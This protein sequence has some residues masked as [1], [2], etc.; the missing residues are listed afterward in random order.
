MLVELA[1]IL[2]IGLVFSSNEAMCWTAR[3]NPAILLVVFGT[4][5]QEAQA[6]YEYIKKIYQK[7]FPS[8]KVKI[9]FTSASIRRTIMKRSNTSIDNPLTGLAHLNDEGYVNVVV[10]SLHMI[11][12][13]EFHDLA[14]VVDSIKGIR[15][16]FEFK[17]LVLGAPLL[18]TMEDYRD[19]SRILSKQFDENKTGAER[20]PHPSPKNFGKMAI[21]LMGHGTKHSLTR[22]WRIC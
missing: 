8:A 10:Q 14:N 2:G 7:K 6:T 17:N 1:E 5:Y 21:I 3:D 22:R 15:G 13:E 9:A 16:K 20:T 4:S 18:M 19:V 11:P 12:G